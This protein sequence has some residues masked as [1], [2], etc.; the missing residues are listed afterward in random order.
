MTCM[1][2]TFLNAATNNLTKSKLRKVQPATQGYTVHY[3]K[4]LVVA[5][6]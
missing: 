5:G 2:V 4:E 1:L 6:T 3:G